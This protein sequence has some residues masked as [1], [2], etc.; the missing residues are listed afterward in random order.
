MWTLIW[1]VATIVTIL[2][3]M[4]LVAKFGGK[5]HLDVERSQNHYL[6]E[7]ET[8]ARFPWG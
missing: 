4:V 7:V 2:L 8:R 6:G 5:G 3:L 1:T